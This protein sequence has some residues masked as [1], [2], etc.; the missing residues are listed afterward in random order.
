MHVVRACD[1]SLSRE[2]VGGGG[3]KP[4]FVISLRPILLVVTMLIL[5]LPVFYMRQVRTKPRHSALELYQ[6]YPCLR[7]VLPFAGNMS[8]TKEWGT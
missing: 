7:T 2:E 8:V 5:K 1:L 6:P 3:G 4:D